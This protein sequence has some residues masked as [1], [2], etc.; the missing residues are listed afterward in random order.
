MTEY[1]ERYVRR[2]STNRSYDPRTNMK[3]NLDGPF[4]IDRG[5]A[6]FDWNMYKQV[7]T[8]RQHRERK[9]A[10]DNNKLEQRF[11]ISRAMRATILRLVF[12]TKNSDTNVANYA[13]RIMNH[14]NIFDP[15]QKKSLTNK[16][17]INTEEQHS[18]SIQLVKGA[19]LK[20]Y[21]D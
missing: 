6:A 12:H 1:N 7:M 14:R 19:G 3:E 11:V 10:L 17:T 20:E 4:V 9:V 21:E 16:T 13:Y 18:F 8:H 15:D 2:F 5:S